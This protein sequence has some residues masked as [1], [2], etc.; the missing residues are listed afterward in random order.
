RFDLLLTH[1]GNPVRL[2][3][4]NIPNLTAWDEVAVAR[5]Y[6]KVL[7][8]SR[9]ACQEG[10]LVVWPESAAWPF[11]F[12]RDPGLRRD[13]AGLVRQGCMVL[14]NSDHAE[15]NVLYNSAYLL[16]KEGR[17]ARYDK[18]HL[19]P[20]GEYVPFRG[21]FS[22]VD[23]LAREAGEYRPGEGARLLPWGDERLG[24]S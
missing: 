10:A 16:S 3:Q 4:P 14:F 21:V 7:G 1:P 24:M 2:L 22:F 5:N 8:L 20:F 9:D 19:V 13:L 23:K 6:A 11:S 17:I 12:E 15:R 18:R